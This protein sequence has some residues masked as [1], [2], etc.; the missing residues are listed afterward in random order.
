VATMPTLVQLRAHLNF[1]DPA[2]TSHDAEVLDMLAAAV[3]VVEH[4][5]DFPLVADALIDG[6]EH[7]A[8][9]FALME[10]VRDMWSGTQTGGAFQGSALPGQLEEPTLTAGRPVLPPYVR[11]LLGPYRAKITTGPSYAFPAAASWPLS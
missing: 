11:G 4:D 3:E 1:N 2:D 6:Q 5:P 10:F 8:L 9:R 7:P